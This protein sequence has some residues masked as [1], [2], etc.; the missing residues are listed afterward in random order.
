LKVLRGQSE[1]VTPRRT[2]NTKDKDK[3][4]NKTMTYKTLHR[5]VKIEQQATR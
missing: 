2:D 4:I 5:K 1:A 3:R